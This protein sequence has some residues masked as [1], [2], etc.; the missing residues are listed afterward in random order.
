[1]IF[2]EIRPIT[3][4]QP[5]INCYWF[6]NAIKPGPPTNRKTSIVSINQTGLAANAVLHLDSPDTRLTDFMNLLKID[7]KWQIVSKIFYG[8]KLD[9]K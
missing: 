9:T 2:K 5:F 6:K 4:L 1:M 8:E 3:P 7:G